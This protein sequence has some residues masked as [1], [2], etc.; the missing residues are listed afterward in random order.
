MV[1]G[2]ETHVCIYQTVQDLLIK[3]YDVH[4]VI[5]PVMSRH[6]VNHNLGLKKMD[7]LGANM[8]SVEMALFELQKIA[9]G[10]TFKA[11]ASIIK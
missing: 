11:L 3:N 8:T 1:C 7:S 6:K 2:I 10:D 4:V 5:D 9:S